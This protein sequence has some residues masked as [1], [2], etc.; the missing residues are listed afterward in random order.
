M[1][2]DLTLGPGI[3]DQFQI[4]F[5]GFI[6]FHNYPLYQLGLG[7]FYQ[8]YKTEHEV[9]QY[10]NCGNNK[11]KTTTKQKCK[12]LHSNDKHVHQTKS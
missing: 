3:I 6:Q 1:F 10:Q 5:V 4:L 11:R 7:I 2:A 8:I 9:S 12:C